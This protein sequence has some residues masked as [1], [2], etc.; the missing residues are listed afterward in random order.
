MSIF[1]NKYS[2]YCQ[3]LVWASTLI[4]TA[5]IWYG[6]ASGY[7]GRLTKVEEDTQTIKETMAAMRQE[8]HD[9]HD[10]VKP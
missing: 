7:D 5:G 4:F 2:S 10:W 9:I 3:A 1:W 6:T 8:I